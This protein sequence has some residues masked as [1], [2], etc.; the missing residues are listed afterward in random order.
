MLYYVRIIVTILGGDEM[1]Y[2]TGDDRNQIVFLPDCIEDYVSEDN[3]VRV[4]DAFV[5]QLDMDDLEFKRAKPND[6]GRPSYD[7]RDLLKLYIYGYFNRIRSS[8]KLMQEC[9]RNLEVMYLIGKLTPDFRT[10][11]DFRKDN[12]KALKRVFKEFA[13]VCLRLN[14]YQRELIAI[15]GSK[16]RA[17]NSKKN[18]YNKVVLEKKLAN[19]ENHINNYLSYMDKED[20]NEVIEEPDAKEINR[21]IQELRERKEK[22]LGYLNE[23]EKSGDKQILTTD[24]DARR[25]HSKDGFHCCY[26]AQTAI[27][28]G[29][30]LIA[31]YSVDSKIDV[32][33]LKEVSEEAKGLLGVASIEVLADKG[34]DSNQDVLDCLMNGTV[35]NVGIKEEKEERVFTIEYIEKDIDE[36]TRESTKPEDIQACLHAGILPKCYEGTSVSIEFQN[37]DDTILSCFSLNDDGTVTCPMGYKLF[38]VKKKGVQTHYSSKI[39]CRFCTNKCTGS[40]TKVVAFGPNTK[41]V[42]IRMNP[43]KERQLPLMPKDAKLPNNFKKRSDKKVLIRMKHIDKMAAERM[44]LSEH[45]FGTV[46]WYN[47]SHYVLCRG[48]EKVTAELGLCFLAYNLRRAI[49]MVGVH[50]LIAAM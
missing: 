3:P 7:P 18:C 37:N 47:L 46:K 6:T 41:Y 43:C 16:F 33:H 42:P 1:K 35:A 2:I 19:I 11:S 44:C 21:V 5:N 20:K 15:D 14:L 22:Y 29:S 28:G 9:T 24:P 25:M 32:G 50:K 34:Y 40:K 17:Q 36:A 23:L 39:A 48:K 4:I 10:I 12:P 26:N 30:H 8:R 27:D 13:K 45:P 38:A 31:G 49:N